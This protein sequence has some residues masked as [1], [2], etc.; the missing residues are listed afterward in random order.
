MRWPA[1]TRCGSHRG[2][3]PAAPVPP[4]RPDCGLIRPRANFE[5]EEPF[6]RSGR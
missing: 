1:P 3:H 2:A 6:C 4:P 5:A